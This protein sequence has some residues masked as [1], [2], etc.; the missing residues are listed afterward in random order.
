MEWAYVY[1]S[2]G[3][4]VVHGL[5]KNIGSEEDGMHCGKCSGICLEAQD[6]RMR[7]V[8]ITGLANPIYI[9]MRFMIG[10]RSMLFRSC[11]KN[12]WCSCFYTGI[13]YFLDGVGFA[14]EDYRRCIEFKRGSGY[15]VVVMYSKRWRKRKGWCEWWMPASWWKTWMMLKSSQKRHA[16]VVILWGKTRWSCWLIGNSVI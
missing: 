2:T 4:S 11:E 8:W 10:K 15:T 13:F 16:F 9:R 3:V 6:C 5:R 1:K 12:R 14:L 7:P